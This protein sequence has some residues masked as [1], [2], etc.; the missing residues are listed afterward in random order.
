MDDEKD[1]LA[2][3]K[4][5]EHLRLLRGW[6]QEHLARA[7]RISNSSLSDYERGKIDPSAAI[8]ARVEEALGGG[9]WFD[10]AQPILGWIL[11]GMEG[12]RSAPELESFFEEMAARAGEGTTVI[13][14]AGLARLRRKRS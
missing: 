10:V 4:T 2:W 11:Q 1:V 6:T 5:V 8:R 9:E 13:L 12:G 3:G 14:R 7:A